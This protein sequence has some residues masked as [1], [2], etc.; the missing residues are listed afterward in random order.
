M[1]R[2]HH[3]LDQEP[4]TQWQGLHQFALVNKTVSGTAA[5]IGVNTWLHLQQATVFLQDPLNFYTTNNGL[6]EMWYVSH[7]HIFQIF[8]GVPISE[9][10]PTP[11]R[12]AVLILSNYLGNLE[13]FQG[14]PLGPSHHNSCH[15]MCQRDM[16]TFHLFSRMSLQIICWRTGAN[17][18]GMSLGMSGS[19]YD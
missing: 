14:L 9:M 1:W 17:S 4:H 18:L 7:P 3:S 8:N 11:Q 6:N 16:W 19:H 13:K 12:D 5:A 10:P 2:K 15:S